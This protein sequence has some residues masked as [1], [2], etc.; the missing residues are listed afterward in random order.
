MSWTRIW[1]LSRLPPSISAVQSLLIHSRPSKQAYSIRPQPKAVT[2]AR[3]MSSEANKVDEV[4]GD[5]TSKPSYAPVEDVEPPERYRPGGY[6]PVHVGD[7]FCNRYKVV[8]KLGF[9]SYSTTWLCW[10]ERTSAYVAIKIAVAEAEHQSENRILRYLTDHGSNP[11]TTPGKDF[12]P[13]LLD[14]FNIQGPNGT[15]RCFVTAPARMSI[16]DARQASFKQ[17]FHAPVARAIAAQLVQAVDFIHSQG[18]VHSGSY[19]QLRSPSQ[20]PTNF[21][22]DLHEGNILLRMPRSI[23]D[24]PPDKFYDEFGSP[25]L[26]RFERL[27]GKPLGAGIPSHGIVAV[28]LG[29]ACEEVTL[30]ESSILLTD[31]GESFQPSTTVRYSSHTPLILRPPEQFFE[32][33]RPLSFPSDIWALACAIFAILGQ[34]P[35]FESWFP[36][37]DRVIEEHVDA[38]GRLPTNWWTKWSSRSES[39]NDESLERV[40]GEARRR[41]EERVEY[42]FIHPA[43]NMGWGTHRNRRRWL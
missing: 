38:L 29:S 30:N 10:D 21:F 28:W 6:H 42:Q 25:E 13:K 36:T 9:G 5:E 14:D 3:A 27:D 18:V 20:Q 43:G 23:D 16:S 11:N 35:L 8:H 24:L 34:R 4:V 19:L 2:S 12:I 26:E 31:F 1:R 15:H 37:E 7:H 41:L 33:T 40:N 22:L 39:F 17:L 32:P